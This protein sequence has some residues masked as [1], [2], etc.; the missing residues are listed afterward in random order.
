MDQQNVAEAGAEAQGYGTDPNLVTP[1]APWPRTLSE[2]ERA[3]ISALADLIL[4][5]TDEYPAP[6]G[7]GIVEFFDEWV[8]APYKTQQQHRTVITTGLAMVDAEARRQ[9]ES[10]FLELDVPRQRQIIDQ[11]ASPTAVDRKFFI[12]FRHLLL[13]GYFT[14]DVGFKAIGYI[15]NVPLLSFPGVTSDVQRII[16]DELEVL[17]L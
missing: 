10:D 3:L 14:S 7:M 9:F 6:S 4:P 15:G 5:G 1:H 16:D 2:H 8:S 17:G 13:G 12:R 11:I